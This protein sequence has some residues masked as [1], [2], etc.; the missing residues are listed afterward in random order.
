[1]AA[2]KKSRYEAKS[3]WPLQRDKWDSLKPEN[4]PG[5]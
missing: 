1:M 5:V 4:E 2:D 3:F